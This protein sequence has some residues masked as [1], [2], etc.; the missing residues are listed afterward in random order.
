MRVRGGSSH[1]HTNT[2]VQ[3]HK[4]TLCIAHFGKST[5]MRSSATINARLHDDTVIYM[6]IFTLDFEECQ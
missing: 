3:A 1:F 5:S 2:G 4:R 6:L